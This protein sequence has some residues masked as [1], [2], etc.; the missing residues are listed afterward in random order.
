MSQDKEPTGKSRTKKSTAKTDPKDSFKDASKK[1]V[2]V[3]PATV[4]PK[5]Q[6]KTEGNKP[7]ND[8]PTLKIEVSKYASL[9]KILSGDNW[10]KVLISVFFIGCVLFSG[11]SL[12]ALA[13][14]KMYPYS[15][16][17][18]NGLGTTTIKSENGEVSYW[19]F[20]SASLWANSGITVEKGDII[21]IRSSGKYHTAIH[22]LYDA[23]KN[24]TDLKDQ[25]IGSEGMPDNYNK[26]VED[27]YRS[28][29]RIFP[30]QPNGALVMQVATNTPFDTPNDERDNKK[31]KPDN[32]Y[33]IGKERQNIYINNSGT[34]YFAIND[35]VLNDLTIKDMLMDCI[36][37]T[38]NNDN[39]SIQNLYKNVKDDLSKTINFL[40]NQFEEKSFKTDMEYLKQ[41]SPDQIN[42]SVD[43]LLNDQNIK[44][45]DIDVIKSIIKEKIPFRGKQFP[46]RI[47]EKIT[48]LA[49][50][51]K[52]Y[53]NDTGLRR[54]NINNLI[55]E[56][57]GNRAIG[58]LK[59]GVSKD[60]KGETVCE[61]KYYHE[62]GYKT[63]WFDD[64]EGSLL[65]VVEKSK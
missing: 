65:I 28:K 22:H 21:T 52:Y 42:L 46:E 29:Y 24:N 16:I 2:S 59:L 20:N 41:V 5:Q 62:K 10:W 6:S 38:Y 56:L 18:T 39:D 61:L 49:S 26:T 31:A 8:E 1:E 11:I 27:D 50:D 47:D 34:L 12:V 35:I 57:K 44:S 9:V 13:I 54:E 45:E 63:A 37:D 40:L 7:K 19:L 15:D 17:T 32:F 4:D 25:W 55:K 23:T 53:E 64:N 43:D 48:K 36:I 3:E 33:F 60:D 14:K 30:G 51:N 58:K